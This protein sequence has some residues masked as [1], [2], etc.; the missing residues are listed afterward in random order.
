MQALII[1]AEGFEDSELFVPKETLEKAGV[2]VHVATPEKGHA[3]H[4]KHGRTLVADLVLRDV[5]VAA[6]DLLLI[7]GG[8]APQT[9]RE[10]ADALRIAKQFFKAANPWRRSATARWC[11]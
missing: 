9:L 8:K 3:F 10:D 2:T 6:Y 7:P 1:T 11:W 4:G 5:D